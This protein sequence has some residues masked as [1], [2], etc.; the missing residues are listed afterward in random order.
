MN[1][2]SLS[3]MILLASLA[4]AAV[5]VITQAFVLQA[6][7]PAAL[8]SDVYP[9]SRFRLPLPT[10]EE[11]DDPGKKVFDQLASPDRVSLV[12]LQGPAGIRLNSPKIARILEDANVYLRRETGFGDRLTEIAIMTTAREM[13]NQFE[14]AAH[15]KAGLKAGVEPSLIDVI[16]F[17]KPLTGVAEKEAVT[18]EFG[19]ELFAQKKVSPETFAHA[20]R[21]YGKRGLV[22]LVSLMSQYWATSSLL[23]AFDMQLPE[24]QKPLLPVK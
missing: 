12:G 5:V 6:Q 24:G 20:L 18:I 15:E 13:E 2:S 11:M 1:V 3:R 10:R 16:K 7:A 17:K 14:W 22:D 21:L 4:S 19:R 8:P 23:T 9:D